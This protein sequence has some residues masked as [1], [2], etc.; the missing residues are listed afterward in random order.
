MVAGRYTKAQ[1]RNLREGKLLSSG[2]FK[3][4]TNSIPTGPVRVAVGVGLPAVAASE[5]CH[6]L[7]L[8][9]QQVFQR[10]RRVAAVPEFEVV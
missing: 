1:G 7:G 6:E 10:A 3:T 5:R 4:T 9:Q 8:A 2:R